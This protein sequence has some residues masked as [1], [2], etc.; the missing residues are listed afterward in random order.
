MINDIIVD[1]EQYYCCNN[2]IAVAIYRMSFTRCY[3]RRIRQNKA[4]GEK[5][6]RNNNRRD[7]S[8]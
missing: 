5:A 8:A 3:R 1:V 6:W 7:G 4:G 2:A